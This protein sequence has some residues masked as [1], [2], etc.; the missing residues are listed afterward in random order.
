M[1]RVADARPLM[2]GGNLSC[3]ISSVLSS[4]DRHTA[5]YWG[6]DGRGDLFRGFFYLM[7]A[8]PGDSYTSLRIDVCTIFKKLRAQCALQIRLLVS[9]SLHC[10]YIAPVLAIRGSG[11]VPS[12]ILGL[13][14]IRHE[15]SS[16]LSSRVTGIKVSY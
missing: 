10:N 13:L 1:S 5:R 12:S 3:D 6:F 2:G 9:S 8:L 14:R 15:R 11:P 7:L 16:R 4:P